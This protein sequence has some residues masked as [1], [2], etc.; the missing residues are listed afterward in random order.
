MCVCVRVRRLSRKHFDNFFVAVG[1]TGAMVSPVST[2]THRLRDVTVCAVPGAPWAPLSAKSNTRIGPPGLADRI[3]NQ[4]I[5]NWL[6]WLW[7]H[8][9]PVV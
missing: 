4:L 5:V 3:N 7:K 8:W 1:R 2:H 9:G 6:Y